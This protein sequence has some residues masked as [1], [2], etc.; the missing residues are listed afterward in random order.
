MTTVALPLSAGSIMMESSRSSDRKAVFSA[1][2]ML[3]FRTFD[4]L[5]APT[6][7]VL[8]RVVSF[9]GSDLHAS[10]VATMISFLEMR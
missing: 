8:S 5:I 6:S 7:S 2:E 3:L 1:L 9:V 4:D 10:S